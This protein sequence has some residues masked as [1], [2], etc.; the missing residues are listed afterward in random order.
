MRP[1]I[2]ASAI[3]IAM[4]IGVEARAGGPPPICMVVDKVVLEPNEQA[5]TR[6]QIWGTFVLLKNHSD[7]GEP[8]TGYLYYAAA[9]GKE[10]ECRKE[11]ANLRRLST[12]KHV[13]G[14]GACGRPNVDGHVRMAG[15]K[16]VAPNVFP[17][18]EGGFANADNYLAGLP[19]IKKLHQ[20]LEL[21]TSKKS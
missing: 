11:W 16:R 12:E 9:P 14:F 10:A 19:S 6:I 21:K 5:P 7:Y 17:L 3:L 4:V 2:W 8:V 18:G 1:T 13:I 20:S 15:D